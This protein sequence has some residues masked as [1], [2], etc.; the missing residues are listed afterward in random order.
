[1]FETLM[2][3]LPKED[4]SKKATSIPHF[5]PV[6]MKIKDINSQLNNVVNMT[7]DQIKAMIAINYH[8]FFNDVFLMDYENR[9]YIIN[10][11]S[12]PRFLKNLIEVFS[13]RGIVIY[14]TERICCNK[15]AWDYFCISGEEGNQEIT[16]L[17][18]QLSTIVNGSVIP[19]LSAIVPLDTAK[20]IALA[21]YSSFKEYKCVERVNNI[22][23]SLSNLSEKMVIDVYSILFKNGVKSTF[24]T[25]MLKDLHTFDSNDPN[26]EKKVNN[27]GLISLAILDIVESMTMS[28][29]QQI[30][31]GY[32]NEFTF[33]KSKKI[34]FSLGTISPNDYPRITQVRELL[35]T[36]MDVIIP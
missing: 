2:Q 34:R 15:I 28:D 6:E 31:L 17:L 3:S 9:E 8:T 35:R 33:D 7:D 19:I 30:L 4:E 20:L 18:Y 13:T 14:D 29:I 27:Y 1:M 21:R 16:K 26:Y 11:F 23:I 5:Q 24:S 32:A 12:N 22:L 25:I 10:V 36:S